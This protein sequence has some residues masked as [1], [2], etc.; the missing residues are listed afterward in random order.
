VANVIIFGIAILATLSSWGYNTGTIWATLGVGSLAVALAAQ[1]TLENFFGGV[2][3]IGDRPVLVGDFCRVGDK[4]GTIEDI[5]LRST[6][7]RT[8]DRTVLTVPNSQFSTMTLEN[9][10]K[11]D[12]MWFHPTFGLRGDSTPRQIRDAM[13][14]FERILRDHPEI[15]VGN[16]PVR[17]TG[18]NTYSFTLE[19]FAYVLTPD[20]DR[21]LAVQSEL[22]LKLLDAIEQAGTGVAVPLYEL[23]GTAKLLSPVDGTALATDRASS[24]SGPG[25]S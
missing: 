1:K 6:R 21:F 18:V 15:E 14:A 2:S 16:V 3:V 22:L 19:I 10:A 17:F 4:V 5:G 25:S 13:A 23:T 24:N 7:I 11:R 12:K 9:F 8:L 20:F